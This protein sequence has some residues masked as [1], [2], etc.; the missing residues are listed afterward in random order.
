VD[1]CSSKKVMII[2]W[3]QTRTLF[4]SSFILALHTL[5]QHRSLWQT[6]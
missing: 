5:D 4:V 3:W 6:P 1:T 2:F